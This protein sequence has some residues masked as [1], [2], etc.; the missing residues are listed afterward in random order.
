MK[1]TGTDKTVQLV[2]ILFYFILRS[3]VIRR[4]YMLRGEATH[5][6]FIILVMT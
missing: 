6:N 5:I 4:D 2:F 3:F 1:D